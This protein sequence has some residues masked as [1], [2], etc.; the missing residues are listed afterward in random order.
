MQY[1]GTVCALYVLSHLH[2]SNTM[3]TEQTLGFID[4]T[5]T[6]NVFG[7]NWE[8]KVCNKPQYPESNRAELNQTKNKVL[9]LFIFADIFSKG[10]AN[11]QE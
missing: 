8:L 10:W 9:S 1:K 3:Q 6:V 5:T 7:S 2:E 4:N 11:H